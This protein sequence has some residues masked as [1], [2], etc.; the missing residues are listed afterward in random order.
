MEKLNKTRAFIT[1]FIIVILFFSIAA[2]ITVELY[3]DANNKSNK[4]I[5]MT[6]AVL[7]AQTVAENIKAG[8]MCIDDGSMYLEYL[9]EDMNFVSEAD[10]VYVECITKNVVNKNTSDAGVEYSYDITISY[11]KSN[12]KLYSLSFRQYKSEEER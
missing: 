1:E 5:R 7:R 9:D 10:A 4:N 8:T 12:E 2:V 6:D 11:S 3:V